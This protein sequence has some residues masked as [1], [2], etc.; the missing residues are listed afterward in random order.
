M[1][2]NYSQTSISTSQENIIGVEDHEVVINRSAL[3]RDPQ[4][5]W[6]KSVSDRLVERIAKHREERIDNIRE[7]KLEI[8]NS[9]KEDFGEIENN[10]Y[11]SDYFDY[12]LSN[13]ESSVYDTSNYKQ[14]ED[15]LN[16]QNINL[17]P[18]CHNPVF[19]Y[20]DQIY[21]FFRCFYYKL[22]K[23]TINE[24]FTLQNFLDVFRRAFEA[25]FKC[26]SVL[27]VLNFGTHVDFMCDRCFH[28]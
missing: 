14:I 4:I 6:R 17:C 15:F 27:E 28:N 23:G 20:N 22:E 26:E 16:F 10:V 19:C 3:K 7:R 18:I 24:D 5:N 8:L 13:I 21:C 1:F 2:N 25:H 12:I 11:L 9:L